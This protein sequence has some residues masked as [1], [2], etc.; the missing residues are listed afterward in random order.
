V[1]AASNA[2]LT[3]KRWADSEWA[4]RLARL[5]FCARG[6]VYVII[7]VL[8]FQVARTGGNASGEEASK[9][10]AL[11]EIAERSFG[12]PLLAVLAVGLAGYALWRFTE[13]LWGKQDEDDEKKRTA[14]RVGSFGKGA[15]YTALLVSTLRFMA[16]GPSQGQGQGGGEQGE[17]SLT[18]KVLDLPAGQWIVGAIGAAIIVGGVYLVYRGAAQKFEKRLDTAEMGPAMGST[19]EVLGTVG[20]IARGVVTGL[21][22]FLLLKAALDYDPNK[23]VGLDG[24]L[25]TIAGQTYGQVLLTITAIGVVAYGLYSFAE[26]RYREL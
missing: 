4:T 21:A 25:K 15:L 13:A 5:G 19:V 17:K 18:A 11:R 22:G 10:G 2:H 16:N 24:T 12:G 9:D 23:A 8:A 26:A 14:K 3:A 7:G 6:V 20:L 1:T